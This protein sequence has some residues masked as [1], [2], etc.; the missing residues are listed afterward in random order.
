[1][2]RNPAGQRRQWLEAVLRET[3]GDRL[4]IDRKDWGPSDPVPETVNYRVGFGS[5]PDEL[6]LGAHH[7]AVPGVPAALDNGGSVVAL[8]KAAQRIQAEGRE[9]SC[10]FA[11]WD[12]EELYGSPYMGSKL[13]LTE[14]RPGRAV[15]F[16]VTGRGRLFVSG[17][18]GAGVGPGL[19]S[20]LTPPSDDRIL[21]AA[22]VPVTLVCA[23]PEGEF[24][25]A[26]PESWRVLHT[27][28]DAPDLAD[29]DSI[30]LTATFAAGVARGERTAY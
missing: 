30:E 16:D 1:M 3:F 13:F 19:P 4:R 20:R 14:R 28:R 15:V 18:D 12:H 29:T 17:R 8:F 7:D 5:D 6:V 23:L 11:F 2:R 22:G 10:T 26:C 25:A 9:P 21:A 24:H 27:V